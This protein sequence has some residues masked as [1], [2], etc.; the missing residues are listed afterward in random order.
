[1]LKNRICLFVCFFYSVFG[2]TGIQMCNTFVTYVCMC[3]IL[4]DFFLLLRFVENVSK[5]V[6]AL[7]FFESIWCIDSRICYGQWMNQLCDDTVYTQ[8]TNENNRCELNDVNKL[9]TTVWYL[10]RYR[11]N[12]NFSPSL[13]APES[14][15]WEHF[16][17]KITVK[18]ALTSNDDV[19]WP[20]AS[21]ELS[22]YLLCV[23]F[24]FAFWSWCAH[25]V[26]IRK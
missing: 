24:F 26:E 7:A 4:V 19:R 12:A 15:E 22:Y 11:R 2:C 3:T 13:C 18:I 1:M 10:I 16:K 21:T 20:V 5:I 17:A 25:C 23:C 8:Y 14:R 6:G 9:L